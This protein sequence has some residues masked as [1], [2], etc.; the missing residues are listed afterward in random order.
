MGRTEQPPEQE[1]THQDQADGRDGDHHQVGKG[2]EERTLG[3]L[4]GKAHERR[5]GVGQA[6][7]HADRALQVDARV[8][9]LLG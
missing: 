3:L 2:D 4:G 5:V 6:G 7:I 9:V 1:S 8:R